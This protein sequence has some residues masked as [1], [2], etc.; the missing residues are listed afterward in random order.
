MPRS[1]RTLCP[2]AQGDAIQHRPGGRQNARSKPTPRAVSITC[3]CARRK[4]SNLGTSQ[5]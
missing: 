3:L 4:L 5:K 2:L 1:A